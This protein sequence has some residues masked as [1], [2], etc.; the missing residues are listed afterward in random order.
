VKKP[1]TIAKSLAIG[2]PADGYYAADTIRRTG[3]WGENPTDDEIVAGIQMLADTEGIFA[4]TAGGV[5]VA[6]TRRLIEAGRI[7]RDR[8]IVLC[9]TGHGLKTKEALEGKFGTRATIKPSL[10]EFDELLQKLNSQN[11]DQEVS[12]P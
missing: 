12:C 9:I 11:S 2:D 6:A 5:T 10:N 4:E 7:G 8:S 1:D 3:G